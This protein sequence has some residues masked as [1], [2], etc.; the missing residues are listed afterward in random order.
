MADH[1]E[2]CETNNVNRLCL[3]PFRL[4]WA[5]PSERRERCRSLIGVDARTSQLQIL[6]LKL[7]LICTTTK[8]GKRSSNAVRSSERRYESEISQ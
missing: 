8:K 4:E 3:S 7:L 5:T 2:M 6:R 1:H